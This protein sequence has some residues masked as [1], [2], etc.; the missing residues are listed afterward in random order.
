VL[1]SL[2]GALLTVAT[3][4][5]AWKRQSWWVRGFD[6]PRLQIAALL[7]VVG[8]AHVALVDPTPVARAFQAALAACLAVQLWRMVPY[9]PLG[10]RQ[11]QDS[12]RADPGRSIRL[13]F[14][15]VLQDNRNAGGLLAL[16]QRT[17]PDVVLAIETDHW[18]ADALEVLARTHPHAV[19]HP[20]DNTYGM[21][22]FSRLELVAPRVRFLVEADVPSIHAQVRLPS[23]S[24]VW[25]HCLHP[26]PPAP[27]ESDSSE[28]RDAELLIIGRE[29]ER[30]PGPVI[31]M[32]D[33]NDVAW[34]HTSHLF[35][36]I[37]GLLDPRVGRGFFNTFNAK[38]RLLRFPL[39]HFFHSSSFRLVEFRRLEAFGSD[40]FPV[41]INLSYEPDAEEEQVPEPPAPEDRHE[42]REKIGAVR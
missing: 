12:R 38:S 28:P 8:A 39:D 20:L 41:F 29:I 3:I 18:W 36:R 35:Q 21:L 22:L 16:I 6:F 1:L 40:H 30:R 27:Q 24:L 31:V 4:L 5:P 33:L 10:R 15:N 11:V 2:L 23:G 19:R 14:A 17:D 7:L 32:G 26:R 9:T 25:V 42:A 13:L 37:S 34:S